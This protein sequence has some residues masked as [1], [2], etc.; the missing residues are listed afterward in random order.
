MITPGLMIAEPPDLAV[1]PTHW[2]GHM[3]LPNSIAER[4]NKRGADLVETPAPA[5]ADP[6]AFLAAVIPGRVK[7]E[8]VGPSLLGNSLLV[9]PI[10]DAARRSAATGRTVALHQVLPRRHSG[11]GRKRNGLSRIQVGPLTAHGEEGMLLFAL[12]LAGSTPLGRCLNSGEAA[13]GVTSA[14]SA[15]FVADYERADAQLNAA[16]R[17]TMS[18]LPRPRQA[19]LRTSQRAWIAERDRAC[20]IDDTPG[21]GTIETL[22]HPG[23]LTKESERRTAWLREVRRRER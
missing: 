1:Y 5:F 20:P 18:R 10:L 22:N 7:V 3:M 16:Y 6:F 2:P 11:T 14:M 21:A 17:A 15:C 13:M 19:A 8:K 12:M 4:V 9:A 23:C